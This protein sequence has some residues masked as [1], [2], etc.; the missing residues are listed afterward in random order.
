VSATNH[1]WVP[2]RA[3][4]IAAHPDDIEFGVAGTVA[5]WADAGTE[6]CYVMVTSG[7]VGIADPTLTREQVRDIREPE[8]REAA[9][10]VGVNEVVFLREP[11]GE[12]VN[13]LDLRRKLVRE[14]RRFRP[15]AVICWDP[16]VLFA[17]EGYINHPDHRAVAMAALDAVFPAAG[18]P[19]VFENL[20][21]E[22]L[23]A[24]KTKKV[25]VTTWNPEL[26]NTWINITTTIERKIKALMAHASQMDEMEGQRP[27]NTREKVAEWLRKGAA[28]RGKGREMDYAEQYRV[29]TLEPDPKPAD[30]NATE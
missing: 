5:R 7:D 27:E 8:Q 21:D 25:Y 6:I 14:I 12:V 17:S 10:V 15:D 11:D 1:F 9:R 30:Q 22:G 2:D 16:T 28:E 19:H 29:I 24:H 18:Q 23:T 3:M 13:T 26:A 4:V 20:K